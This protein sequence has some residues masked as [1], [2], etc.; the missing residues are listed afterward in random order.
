M[1]PRQER[2]SLRRQR[3]ERGLERTTDA[4][5]RLLAAGKRL[6]THELAQAPTTRGG[7]GDCDAGFGQLDRLI[8]MSLGQ[9]ELS[10]ALEDVAEQ[11]LVV[12]LRRRSF[13]RG[14]GLGRARVLPSLRVHPA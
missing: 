5:Q 14:E 6:R 1:R 9:L 4:R 8:R 13:C 7:F 12:Q 3:A 11:A 2:P 10:A